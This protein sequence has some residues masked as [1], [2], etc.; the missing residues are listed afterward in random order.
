MARGRPASLAYHSMGAGESQNSAGGPRAGEG[1]GG[2]DSDPTGSWPW[3]SGVPWASAGSLS[4]RSER[5]TMT[6]LSS[7]TSWCCRGRRLRDASHSALHRRQCVTMTSGADLVESMLKGRSGPGPAPPPPPPPP[8]PPAD[9][10]PLLF[11]SISMTASALNRI[12]SS[13]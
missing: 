12:G 4:V 10:E 9:E 1:E 8:L 2:S 7:Q 11:W 13:W 3:P 5:C 6:S